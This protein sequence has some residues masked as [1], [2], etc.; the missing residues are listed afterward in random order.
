MVQLVALAIV[1][2][3]SVRRRNRQLA[4]LAVLA[5]VAS[6]VGLWSVTRIQ[7]RIIDHEVFWLTGI[8]VLNVG[9]ISAAAVVWLRGHIVSS[10]LTRMGGALLNASLVATC[11][12]I[13]L[14]QIGRARNGYVPMTL[15]SPAV[16]TLGS[17]SRAYFQASGLKR[18]LVRIGEGV[19][20]TA[21]GV[22]LELNRLNVSSAVEESWQSMFPQSFAVSGEED[23]QI[24]IS[25]VNERPAI[26][27]ESGFVPIANAD[28]IYVDAVR[29]EKGR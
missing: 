17:E 14:T 18:P 26:E 24:K 27:G 3:W 4:W 16:A 9:V 6:I 21:A 13:G 7:D 2:S 8:G 20:G 1:A 15:T 25:T 10:R 28:E 5:L 22:L 12:L 11:V 19:W 23:V 29:L